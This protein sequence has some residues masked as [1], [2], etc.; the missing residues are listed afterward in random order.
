MMRNRLERNRE[1]ARMSRKRRRDQ[2]RLLDS[3]VEESLLELRI[4]R[5]RHLQLIEQ[6][7][8]SALERAI[9]YSV[10]IER[11]DHF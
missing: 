5:E 8:Q 3:K 7:H 6:T 11:K 10:C 1:S 9:R 4:A 2:Q